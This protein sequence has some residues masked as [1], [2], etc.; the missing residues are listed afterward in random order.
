MAL[1]AS[2]L[3]AES[4]PDVVSTS[5]YVAV[6]DGT[7]LAMSVYRPAVS[8]Q[9]VN[10]PLPVI[11][12]FTPYRGRFKGPDGKINETA[13]GDNLGLRSLLRAGYVVAVADVR[14]KGASFGHRRGFQDRTEALDGRDLV[15]WLAEQPFSDGSVGMVGCSY[16]GGS[17]FQVATTAPPSL[18]A[19]FIGASDLDKYAFVRNGG[20]TA[21]FNTRPDEEPEV[22]LATVPMDEDSDG[23][24]LKAAVAEHAS[25]TPMGPLWYGMPY[26][27]SSSTLTGTKFWEEVGPYNYL[28]TVKR[29]GIATYFWGNWRDEP[30]SQIILSAA[31]L[32]SRLLA[33]PGGHCQPP[34]GF[35]LPGEIVHF[36]D[37]YLKGEDPEYDKLPRATYWVEGL[38]GTGGYVTSAELP[39]VRSRPL[40]WFLSRGGFGWQTA[41]A[42]GVSTFTVDYDLPP[43][44]YFAFWPQPMVD[45]GLGFTSAPLQSDIEFVGYPV[46]Q[47][48]VSSDNP[49]ADVFVYLDR[50]KTDG[51]SEVISFGRLKLSHHKLSLAPYETLGLPWHSGFAKDVDAPAP[52]ADVSL[53]IAMTPVSLVVPAGDSLRFVVAGA[54]PRQRNLADI[55]LNPAPRITVRWGGRDGSRV[56]L[57]LS[58]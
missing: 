3:S 7:R 16:L 49:K 15:E 54:D 58:N 10:K 27:D 4:Y 46:A 17:A 9:A 32:S 31:N 51:T 41:G 21:Q 39:G 44:E 30:T 40:P 24:M 50:V 2:P 36:F 38:N 26:R 13:L 43:A 14:G 45:H 55:K 29:A 8:G 25:N 33:G 53:S 34:Q 42:A 56:D 1:S 12:V 6:R 11:F 22:D 5:N 23:S 20:I 57:P 18:K 47:L 48:T 35:D 37:H 52:G 19:A 28:D